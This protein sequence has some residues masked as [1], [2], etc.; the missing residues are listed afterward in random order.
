MANGYYW[1][2]T[3]S[4][5]EEGTTCKALDRMGPYATADEARSWRGRHEQRDDTWE[6]EDKR[7]EEQN[8]DERWN[9]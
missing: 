6:A 7:W 1:C 2:F 3:H 9:D 8:A 5:V 4:S